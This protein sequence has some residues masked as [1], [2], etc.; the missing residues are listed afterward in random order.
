[1]E[2]L[3]CSLFIC[4]SKNMSLLISFFIEEMQ[5]RALLNLFNENIIIP[6]LREYY[7][8]RL[9]CNMHFIIY[10]KMR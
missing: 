3:Q 1:M 8:L 7:N 4:C 2:Y 9:N 10:S 5:R 6:I